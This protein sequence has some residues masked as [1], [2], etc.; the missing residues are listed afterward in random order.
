MIRTTSTPR[1]LPYLVGIPS[2]TNPTWVYPFDGYC[3]CDQRCQKC[4]KLKKTTY[5]ITNRGSF[6]Q[7]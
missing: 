2:T 7:W 5:T 6:T 1:G 3:D 4:G